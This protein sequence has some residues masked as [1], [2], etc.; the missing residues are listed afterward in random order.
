MTERIWVR[1]RLFWWS[2]IDPD[3]PLG[4][5]DSHTTLRALTRERVIEKW[6]RRLRPVPKT[7]E[8]VP[9]EPA[10]RGRS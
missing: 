6:R 5:M 10:G 9:L 2:A 7:Y 4:T 3:E 8:E 1:R